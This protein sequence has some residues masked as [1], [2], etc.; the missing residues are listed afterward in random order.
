ML[1]IYIDSVVTYGETRENNTTTTTTTTTTIIANSWVMQVKC[2]RTGHENATT[3]A[4]PENTKPKKKK[5]STTTKI[6][7]SEMKHNTYSMT[8]GY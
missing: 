2:H 1:D 4:R 7:I 6:Y 8:Q 3:P 5:N